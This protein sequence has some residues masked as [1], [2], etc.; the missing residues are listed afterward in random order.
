MTIGQIGFMWG[1]KFLKGV[2]EPPAKSGTETDESLLQVGDEK[3]SSLG[4]LFSGLGKSPKHLIITLIVAA[5]GCFLAFNY[6]EGGDSYAWSALSVFIALVIGVLMMV[7]KEINKIEKDRFIVLLISFL[8]VIVFWGAFEQAGGLM[9]IYTDVK[10]DRVVPLF[11]LDILFFGGAALLLLFGIRAWQ[12]KQDSRFIYLPIAGILLLVYFLLRTY[13][14]TDPYEIPT[15]V[16]QSV[17]ALFIIIFGTVVG[18]FWIW[19]QRKGREASSLLKMAVGTIIMGVGFL[20]MAKASIDIQMYGDKAALMLLI[21]AYFFHTIGELC[22]SPVALS[23]ITK[24]APVKYVSLMMGVY[25]AATGF[26]N[27]VAGTIGELTQAEPVKT[28]LVAN[29][30]QLTPYL[31]G[32]PIDSVST[33]NIVGKITLE[34]GSP[35]I[36]DGETNLNS[37]INLD[38]ENKDIL[39]NSLETFENESGDALTAVLSFEKEDG[40]FKGQVK[41]FEIQDNLELRTFIG[42]FIFTSA[43][44]I[45]LLLFFRKLKKL[46][47]GAEEMKDTHDKEQEGYEIA[48]PE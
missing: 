42:I 8:I 10:I 12:K 3:N 23:F 20:F 35:V 11:S 13:S 28:E 43:F 46:T 39:V 18:G 5:L 48:D 22:A 41:V 2:G 9:N 27:K 47:H 24:L 1:Q 19:W 26:G 21:L 36:T 7:Y 40:A 44:G 37:F 32:Q 14:L 25:F 15:A 4:D 17:N 38:E 33:F 29:A 16:F 6:T 34:N 31:E 30:G 45:L